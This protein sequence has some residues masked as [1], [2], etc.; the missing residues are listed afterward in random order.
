MKHR[1]KVETGMDWGLL[2]FW[3]AF[4]AFAILIGS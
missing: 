3:L 2:L 4:F 1:R